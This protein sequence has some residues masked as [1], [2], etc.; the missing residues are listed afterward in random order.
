M[1]KLGIGKRMRDKRNELN[2]FLSQL[3]VRTGISVAHLSSMERGK[4]N[5]SI[6]YL[7]K[8]SEV[9]GISINYLLYG[10]IEPDKEI[11]KEIHEIINDCNQHEISIIIENAKSLKTILRRNKSDMSI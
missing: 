6:E 5:F 4:S 10:D 11:P 2:W 8:I 9:L 3:S 7:V 1:D